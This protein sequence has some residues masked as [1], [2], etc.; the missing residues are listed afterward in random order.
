M[1]I[2]HW[3]VVKDISNQYKAVVHSYMFV[4]YG[5]SILSKVTLIDRPLRG[6]RFKYQS[7]LYPVRYFYYY[8]CLLDD[9]IYIE[10]MLLRMVM[11]IHAFK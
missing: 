7:F 6:K 5:E 1:Y 10:V 3:C 8:F 2:G 4:G 11:S 9:D